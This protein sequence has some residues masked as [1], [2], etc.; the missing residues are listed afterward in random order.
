MRICLTGSQGFIG[1]ALK[2][3]FWA[4]GYQK[5][6]I[7]NRDGSRILTKETAE[8]VLLEVNNIDDTPGL[9]SFFA[10]MKPEIIINCIGRRYSAQVENYESNLTATMRLLF[11]QPEKLPHIFLFGSAAEYA[12][13]VSIAEKSPLKTPG[14]ADDYAFSKILQSQWVE[15]FLAQNRLFRDKI[16]ILRPFN[17]IDADYAYCKTV[18]MAQNIHAIGIRKQKLIRFSLE[19]QRMDFF[20]RDFLNQVIDRLIYAEEHM[21]ILPPVLNI[22]TGIGTSYDEIFDMIAENFE[23]HKFPVS[24]PNPFVASPNEIK[25]IGNP[26]LLQGLIDLPEFNLREKIKQICEKVIKNVNG[27]L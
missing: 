19:P 21:A 15:R 27:I 4:H 22:C 24:L 20:D 9:K 18:K 2:E 5:G 12:S 17:I 8:N 13:G 23:I 16:T 3:Y 11:A 7:I 26:A 25:Y 14:D 1:S 10:A 6:S